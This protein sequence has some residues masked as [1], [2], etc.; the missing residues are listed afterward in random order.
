[1]G[2]IAA[3]LCPSMVRRASPPQ[4]IHPEAET[5]PSA[6]L[7]VGGPSGSLAALTTIPLAGQTAQ[8][9]FSTIFG[10]SAPQPRNGPGWVAGIRAMPMAFTVRLE[11]HPQAMF[12]AREGAKASP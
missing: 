11:P 5:V 9:I 8:M 10:N 4:A 2:V 7:T 3:A 12:P 1:M 6:G